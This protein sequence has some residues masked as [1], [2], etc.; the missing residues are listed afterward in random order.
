M[1]HYDFSRMG[2]QQ[3]EHMV[4]A[5]TRVELGN[6]VKTFGS[7]SDGKREATF[8]G[9]VSFPKGVAGGTWRGYGVVQAKYL[10][11][12]KGSVTLDWR[13]A[14]EAAR[15]ELKDWV[16]KRKLGKK[17]PQYFLF[18]T[19]VVMTPGEDSGGKDQFEELM[20]SYRAALELK[21]WFLWDDTELRVMLDERTEIRRR[22]LEQIVV[23][24]VLVALEHLAGAVAVTASQLAVHAAAELTN[25]QWV[26]T[27]DA[28]YRDNSKLRLA[29][30]GIDLPCL[31]LATNRQ[32]ARRT[33]AAVWTLRAGDARTKRDGV[34][35]V[36]GPGQGKST[37]AQLIAHAYRIAFI[38]GTDRTR[39]GANSD[40]AFQDLRTRLEE[41]RIPLPSKRRWP[42]FLNL[43]GVGAALGQADGQ[44][45]LLRHIA[46]TL[47]IEGREVD[48]GQLFE[49][50]KSWPVCLVLDGLDEVPDAR[51]RSRLIEAVSSFVTEA[52]AH[53]VDLFVVG[54]TR[55]QGYRGEFGDAL[56]ATT[57][58]LDELTETEALEYS[59]ALVKVRHT[60]DPELAAQVTERLIEAVYEQMTQRLMTTPL[61]VTIMT[62]L[63][64]RKVDLPTSRF[65]LFDQYYQVMYDREVTKND[66]FVALRKQRKHIDHLHEIAA[67]KL[68]KVAEQPASSDSTL[69]VRDVTKI[70]LKRLTK[71]GHDEWKAKEISEEI[72]RLSNER[73]V[74]LVHRP[75]S[76]YEFEVRSLQE[77]MAARAITD[78]P[79][80]LVLDRL[81]RLIPSTH[82]RNTWLLAAGRILRDREHL[83]EELF[84]R[85]SE[86]DERD[87][88]RRLTLLGTSLATDLVLDDIASGFPAFARQL[89]RAALNALR[90]Y[91]R[92]LPHPTQK[93]IEVALAEPGALQEDALE[94]LD[95]ISQESL[96]NLATLYLH[97]NKS[98]MSPLAKRARTTLAAGRNYTRPPGGSSDLSPLVSLIRGD[99][100]SGPAAL[101]LADQMDQARYIGLETVLS[102]ELHEALS[103]EDARRSLVR[104]IKSRA[105]TWNGEA[106]AGVQLL[107]VFNSRLA[108]TPLIET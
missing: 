58:R 47:V 107:R 65:E 80:E 63:A 34:V 16:G 88:E 79:D 97:Q 30:V 2:W 1:S 74:M 94:Q 46:S 73:L 92:D 106:E 66:G 4:Q 12:T 5:L 14:L 68:H 69:P 67:F 17:T 45:S 99:S 83:V 57:A 104:A 85:V 89:Q 70:L 96:A 49:W 41:A 18:A 108:Y 39:F 98:G 90:E 6:G 48:A 43:S 33:A 100:K 35:L 31:L 101:A 11:R 36:G 10:E 93:V 105:R 20:E 9:A 75:R 42:V 77:Y 71:A 25:K 51:I 26:R 52:H 38:S 84:R 56:Q 72:L 62:A 59:D 40:I 91:H 86:Y 55:L 37:L 29:D 44:F 76:G 23:G 102:E 78:G 19:N 60:N 3:F 95:T 53:E 22:Y 50:M 24:D 87:D 32:P 8:T 28:G 81:E 15:D 103:V 13:W 61:Q 82:W 54:T 64:E 7:G 21:G 27:G